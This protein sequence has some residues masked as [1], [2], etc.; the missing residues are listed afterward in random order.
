MKQKEI[1]YAD[2]N[3][4]RGREQAG[5]R[6]VVIISGN[7]LNKYL[8]I[9]IVCPLTTKVKHYKGNV[10]MRPAVQNGLTQTSEVLVFHVRSVAKN[11]LMKKIGVI[12]QNELD[13]IKQGLNEILKY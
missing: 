11:R 12:T 1:W 2:L 9:V 4:V 13:S 10:V 3:P 7:V 6:P 5:Y 8:D